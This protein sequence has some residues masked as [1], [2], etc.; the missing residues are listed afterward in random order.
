MELKIG[1]RRLKMI[2][3]KVCIVMFSNRGVEVKS[4]KFTPV[5]FCDSAGYNRCKIS[6]DGRPINL[7]EH[8]LVWKLAH[9]DWDIWD[10]SQDNMIDHINRDR[11]D[12]RLEN[13]HVVNNQ[14]NT[15]NTDAKGYSL[16][17]NGKYQADIMVD[18]VK[19]YLGTFATEE[20]AHSSYLQ[21]KIKYH[22]IV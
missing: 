2:D 8:R 14:Q 6:V 18:G 4:G 16:R 22:P 11:R 1:N 5:K 12:N 3:G 20:E 15:W 10:S 19:N 13:L 17:P 21:G 7:L 9:P